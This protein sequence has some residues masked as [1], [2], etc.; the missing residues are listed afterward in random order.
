MDMNMHSNTVVICVVCSDAV[1]IRCANMLASVPDFK[2][3][4]MLRLTTCW[5]CTNKV[6]RL[7]NTAEMDLSPFLSTN[8][9][10]DEQINSDEI[11]STGSD[12]SMDDLMSVDA[13]LNTIVDKR[14]TEPYNTPIGMLMIASL[15]MYKRLMSY[16]K[17]NM[18]VKTI[19]DF[20]VVEN[21]SMVMPEPLFEPVITSVVVSVESD[22]KMSS[23]GCLHNHMKETVEEMP[24]DNGTFFGNLKA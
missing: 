15:P 1:I 9:G 22:R 8:I 3:M 21:V 16:L 12:S 2:S 20:H 17:G 10:V 7:N 24:Y 6:W 18:M 11:I 4:Y 14:L 13:S 23:C 19:G 5:G